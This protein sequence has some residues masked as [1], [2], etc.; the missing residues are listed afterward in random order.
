[1]LAALRQQQYV[2]LLLLAVLVLL[3]ITS[4]LLAWLQPQ[5]S[6]PHQ[7]QLVHQLAVPLMYFQLL[8]LLL[9]Q[10]LLP[11]SWLPAAVAGCGPRPTVLCGCA[12]QRPAAG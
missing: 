4:Q 9:P 2:L 10:R 12:P 1:M 8:P 3:A 6:S 11:L 5:L 7:L